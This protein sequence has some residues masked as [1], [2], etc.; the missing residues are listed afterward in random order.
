MTFRSLD[1]IAS[2]F[3]AIDPEFTR[4]TNG[5]QL[6][7]EF[8]V[9]HPMDEAFAATTGAGPVVF[10]L[11]VLDGPEWEGVRTLLDSQLV[12]QPARTELRQ[13]GA[14]LRATDTNGDRYLNNQEIVTFAQSH[15]DRYSTAALFRTAAN[16]YLNRLPSY[17]AQPDLT[18]QQI[19][20]LWG[21]MNRYTQKWDEVGADA[22]NRGTLCGLSL[23]GYP[24]TDQDNPPDLIRRAV[25]RQL[26]PEELGT[27]HQ[28]LLAPPLNPEE[29]GMLGSLLEGA[30]RAGRTYQGMTILT[31]SSPKGTR[32]SGDSGRNWPRAVEIRRPSKWR[33]SASPG[34]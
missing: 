27:V 31:G 1:Q 7:G 12:S 18:D 4:I 32:R 13:L 34:K 14:D 11:G 6:L 24:S 19:S 28:I 29:I 17:L 25:N 20:R 26:T 33:Y 10:D 2:D 23:D 8:L 16:S 22:A 5:N 21:T 3:R 30:A 15:S 9:D